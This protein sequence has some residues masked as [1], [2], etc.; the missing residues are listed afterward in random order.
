MEWMAP[1]SQTKPLWPSS[2]SVTGLWLAGIQGWM[3]L[4]E[5]DRRALVNYTAT[6]LWNTQAS[7]KS[8][9]EVGDLSLLPG[10]RTHYVEN[11]LFSILPLLR[12]FPFKRDLR[13]VGI[14]YRF[15]R[16]F[17]LSELRPRERKKVNFKG[18][19]GLASWARVDEHQA[20]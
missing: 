18:Q 17:A 7:W 1:T 6:T 12:A 10:L 14:R 15:D 4:I 19:G 11:F 13:L 2:F 16:H 20:K 3:R 8:N 9:C 5:G